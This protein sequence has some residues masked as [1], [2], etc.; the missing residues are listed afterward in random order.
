[1]HRDL[2]E[3][4]NYSLADF[5]Y[6]SLSLDRRPPSGRKYRHVVDA[7]RTVYWF[8][9]LRISLRG[10]TLHSIEKMLEPEAFG[11]SK[12]GGRYRRNKWPAYLTG[13]HKPSP[14]FVRTIDE[15]CEGSGVIFDHVLWDVLHM[16]SSA[17]E[18]SD[19]WIKRLDPEVQTFL[20]ESA[21]RSRDRARRRHKRLG[22]RAL[23]SIEQ[24]AGLDALACLTLL[25]RESHEAGDREY[26]FTVSYWLCRMLLLMG[27]TLSGHGLARPLYDYYE[28]YI[29]P[30]GEYN[31]MYNSYKGLDFLYLI[32]RFSNALYHIRGFTPDGDPLSI[33][34][35]QHMLK[36]LNSDYGFDYFELF[37][38]VETFLDAHSYSQK[39]VT[40]YWNAQQA[41][42]EWARG[43]CLLPKESR[44]PP[45]DLMLNVSKSRKECI[46]T[47]R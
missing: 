33:G 4:N 27:F 1:M 7:F 30:L 22:V 34:N 31:G 32:S 47:S 45:S 35:I 15:R 42:R 19:D 41:L 29:L 14:T 16:Q 17:A 12:E 5:M 3:S 13:R 9:E 26:A 38:P 18:C 20:L 8:H 10:K 2:L 40:N 25:T 46:S 36:I 6:S 37:R 28:A 21:T 43:A 11:V 39:S 23:K 24:H 44:Y